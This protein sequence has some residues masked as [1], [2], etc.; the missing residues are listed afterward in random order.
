MA[1]QS[2]TTG[3]RQSNFEILRMIAMFMVLLMH[4][5]LM[6]VDA[7]DIRDNFLPT[8][9]QLFFQTISLYGVNLFILISGWFSIKTSVRGL[10]YLLFQVYY[11]G[12]IILGFL[13]VMGV[14]QFTIGRL[15]QIVLLHKS[16]WF[17]VS[18]VI[19]YLLSP[20]LN[21]FSE[22][23]SKKEF[24]AFLLSY[25]AMLVVYGYFDWS[26]QI[27]RGYSALSMVGIYLLGRYA[28][29]YIK[30]NHGFG[31]FV[32]C[33][34]INFVLTTLVISFDLPLIINSYDN[35][36]VILGALGLILYFSNIKVKTS[37][38]INYIAKS[39][40]AV[41]LFHIYP[42]VMD[43]FR[44]VCLQLFSDSSGLMCLVKM[45]IFL[46]CVYAGSVILDIPR[47]LIWKYVVKIIER[48]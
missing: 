35:P 3:P 4:A 11:F 15:Y 16:G 25:F 38:T 30:F 14:E 37:K 18:Y 10:S 46:L 6:H 44:E 21:K 20:V 7:P 32:V 34:L 27:G 12:I 2:I 28:R 17:V 47:R 45:G 9:T 22:Y 48:N 31:L 13:T 36:F 29:Q 8:E 33:T 1:I 26:L 43:W 40:F 41:Y 42:D 23:A 24:K 39:T 19:L 5:N